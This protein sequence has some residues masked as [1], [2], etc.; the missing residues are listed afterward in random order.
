MKS[1][2]LKT[3]VVLRRSVCGL[4]SVLLC[5][6]AAPAT[7]AIS[8]GPTPN[9]KTEAEQQKQSLYEQ[10]VLSNQEKLRVGQERHERLMAERT[11]ILAGMNS[12]YQSRLQ[13]VQIRPPS[14]A[15]AATVQNVAASSFR[16]LLAVALVSVTVGCFAFILRQRQRERMA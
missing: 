14:A 16:P 12:E 5:G 11:K 13:A 7:A 6:L 10:A 3:I 8:H 15:P 9:S 2:N 4:A 1:P